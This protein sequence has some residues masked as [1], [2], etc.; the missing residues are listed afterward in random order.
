MRR[1]SRIDVNQPEIVAGLREAGVSVEPTH[2][3]GRGFPDI[4]C[5]RAC[6]TF[7]IEIKP[8]LGEL[9]PDE[10]DWHLAWRGQVAIART[11]EDALRIVGLQ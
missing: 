3:V 8:R 2:F 6:Q 1:R 4:V 10:M 5:G 7:L 9:T 11:I